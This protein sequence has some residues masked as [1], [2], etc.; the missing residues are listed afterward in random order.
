MCRLVKALYGHPDSG[1]YWEQHCDTWVRKVGFE[2]IHEGWPSC[3]FHPGLKLFLVLYVDDF[4]LAGP[5][6][7]LPAGWTLLRKHLSIEQSTP[8]GLYLGCDHDV[9]TVRGADGK[10]VVVM[11][12][13]IVP[14]VGN[15]LF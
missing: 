4:K 2:P 15:C 1:A 14:G 5:T 8:V 10:P 12:H 13:N 9:S 11:Q 6:A 7:N 3:Y